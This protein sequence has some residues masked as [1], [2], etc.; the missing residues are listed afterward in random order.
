MHGSCFNPQDCSVFLLVLAEASNMM[1]PLLMQCCSHRWG[2]Q[3]HSL[4]SSI[5]MAPPHVDLFCHKWTH[6]PLTVDP[7]LVTLCKSPRCYQNTSGSAERGIVRGHFAHRCQEIWRRSSSFLCRVPVKGS[8]VL[9]RHHRTPT[10]SE[11][12]LP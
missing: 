9:V 3:Q 4:S 10:F 11:D 8:Q 12:R 2:L 1:M 6:D 7:H 5:W